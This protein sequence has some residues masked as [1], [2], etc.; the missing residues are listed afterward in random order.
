M[1]RKSRASKLQSDGRCQYTGGGQGTAPLLAARAAD[2]SLAHRVWPIL[3]LCLLAG[4]CY[5][6]ADH[7]EFLFDSALGHIDNW[8]NQ[9]LCQAMRHFGRGLLLPGQQLSSLTFALNAA[10]NRAIGL[11]DFDITTF[12]AVNVLIH[13]ANACLVYVLIRALLRQIEPGRAPGTWIALAPA[14]WFAVH[15]IAA[16]SVAYVIQRRG[17]LAT[18]FYLLAVLA[19]LAVRRP[20]RTQPSSPGAAASPANRWKRPFLIVWCV[21]AYWLSFKS[22]ELGLTLPFAILGIEFCIRACDR[23]SLRRFLALLVPGLAVSVVGMFAFLWYRGLF[24]PGSPTLRPQAEGELWGPWVHFLTESR[25]FVHYWKL[26]LLPLPQWSCI[27]HPFALSNSLWEHGAFLAIMFHAV[28]LALAVAAA[29]RGLALAGAGVLWFYA[30]LAPYVLLPQAELFVEYKTYLPSVGAALILAEGLRAIRRR[31]AMAIQLPVALAIVATLALT[32][33]SRNWI[34][35]NALNLWSD[36]VAKSP[37]NPRAW[38]GLAMAL[39]DRG[40]LDKAVSN[41][42]TALELDPTR[43]QAIYNLGDVFRRKGDIPAAIRQ[44]EQAVSLKEDFSLGHCAL[45]NALLSIGQVERAKHHYN[46]AIEHQPDFADAHFNLGNILANE[47][48]T[49]GAAEHYR[50]AIAANPR[51]ASSH[52]ALGNMLWLQGDVLAA[53]DQYRAALGINPDH[54]FAH[55]NLG[56]LLCLRGNFSDGIRHLEEAMRCRPEWWE[57]VDRLAT[58]YAT[59]PDPVWRNPQKAIALAEQACRLGSDREPRAWATL[60]VACAADGRLE[61]ARQAAEQAVRLASTNRQEKLADSLR[62]SLEPYLSDPA[63]AP[64]NGAPSTREE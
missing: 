8:Q 13:A 31:A 34:Y 39:A 49:A 43:V 15:P 45:G 11:A 54:A 57:P 10:L 29:R 12:L 56:E 59:S 4:I 28:L 55:S 48:N 46:L 35:Q 22:K 27:D 14:M 23:N 47:A 50:R 30:A 53:I 51:H 17:S 60:A 20:V 37:D 32:T 26:L 21:V 42:H 63:T 16:G 36:A 1:S 2:E 38:T 61:E 18:F 44:Y 25:A 62:R 58:V 41:L 52:S 6:N 33:I 9:D 19:C 24:D 5:L 40:D 64:S 3:L 7:E